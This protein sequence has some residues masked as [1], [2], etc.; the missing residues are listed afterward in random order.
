MCYSHSKTL[1]LLYPRIVSMHGYELV[2]LRPVG[3]L[4]LTE[5]LVQVS[6]G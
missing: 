5:Y 3:D 4:G 6:V 2:W 1:C